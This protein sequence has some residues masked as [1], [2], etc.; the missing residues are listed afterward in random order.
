[1]KLIIS[2]PKKVS[3]FATIFN[4]LKQ[5]SDTMVIYLNEEKF[6]MQ[7]LDG[8]H[9]CLFEC[10]LMA[11]WFDSYEY[12]G[13]TDLPYIAI[14]TGIFY[15][16]INTRDTN[17]TIEL[18]IEPGSDYLGISFTSEDGSF[19]KYFDI[20]L[21]DL[22]TDM[23]EITE[24]E[25]LVDLTMESDKFHELMS[26]LTI[27]DNELILYFD[28]EKIK[29]SAEG[30]EGS[31]RTEIKLDDVTEYAVAEDSNL[32][33]RYALKYINMMCNF[34]KLNSEICLGFSEDRPMWLK[35]N[36]ENESHVCFHLAPKISDE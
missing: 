29:V 10:K 16:I 3:N 24:S 14:N 35:Y 30:N 2:T 8:C 5:F 9:C 31:M 21:I 22:Q 11:E 19:D 4:N 17:Q 18:S 33:Q 1:M 12:A 20:P 13:E 36:L 27:F 7:G 34:R 6:Y 32:T 23:M 28:E 25:T 15:K 26:Q